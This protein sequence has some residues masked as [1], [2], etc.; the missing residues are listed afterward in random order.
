MIVQ[1]T[2]CEYYRPTFNQAEFWGANCTEE[3]WGCKKEDEL[4]DDNI[5]CGSN[6]IL[7]KEATNGSS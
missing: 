7:Y 5:T 6:C 2:N 3:L 4:L 1:Q